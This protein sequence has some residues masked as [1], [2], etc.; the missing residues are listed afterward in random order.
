MRRA[1]GEPINAAGSL[2][3]TLMPGAGSPAAR[4]RARGEM[5]VLA[6]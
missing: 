1:E 3:G 4:A 2:L 5:H 6:I